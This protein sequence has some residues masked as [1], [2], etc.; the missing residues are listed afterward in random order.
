MPIVKRITLLPAFVFIGFL[1]FGC[2]TLAA[3]NRT[4]KGTVVDSEGKPVEGARVTIDGQD[5]VMHFETKTNKNGEYVYLVGMQSGTFRMV[6]RRDGFQPAFKQNLVPPL[7]EPLVTDFTLKSG[8]DYP[9]PWEL[10]PEEQEAMLKQHEQQM[11]RKELEGEIKAVFEEGRAFSEA[12]NHAQAIEAFNRAL[13]MAPDEPVIYAAI[14]KA[15][16]DLGQNEEALASYNKAI[17][18]DAY[19]PSLYMNKGVVL[20][21]LG[22]V[23]E[24]RESFKKSAEL[25]PANAAQT[26]YNLGATL[27]NSGDTLGAIEAFKQ[28]ITSDP[29]YAEAYY[30]LGICLSGVEERVPDAI[31]ALNKYTEIGKKPD[32][33]EV[34]KQIIEVLGGQ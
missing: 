24:A 23:E 34:A 4:F 8:A 12:G 15:Q 10:S 22:K 2:G 25:D 31:E 14:A 13:E 9:L 21:A 29:N 3:Q 32:Q 19:N 6:V 33:V 16:N 30:Q 20:N 1:V 26:Y 27:V 17:E 5:I 18:F 11:K 28:S 7:G